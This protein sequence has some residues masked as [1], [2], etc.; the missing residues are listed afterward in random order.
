MKQISRFFSPFSA[1]HHSINYGPQRTEALAGLCQRAEALVGLR[2][3][4]LHLVRCLEDVIAKLPC[5]EK[6]AVHKKN[7][8]ETTTNFHSGRVTPLMAQLKL[9]SHAND[10]FI[11]PFRFSLGG[12]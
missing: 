8:P 11:I 6:A 5:G 4:Q 10:R 3:Q 9:A 7:V 2:A 1:R 12:G